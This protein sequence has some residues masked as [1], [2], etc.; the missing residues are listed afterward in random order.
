[1]LVIENHGPIILSSNF[2]GSEMDR[3]GRLYLSI[4]AGA[5]RLLL[6]SGWEPM[7]DEMRTGKE[8]IFSRGP[9]A[10][11]PGRGEDSLELLFEDGTD[12]PYAVHF[13]VAQAD[14]LPLDE[15]AGRELV[16]AAWTAPRRGKPH[17]GLERPLWYRRVEAVP[18]LKAREGG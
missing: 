18:C 9:W 4:N 14:R 16:F 7:L 8:V 2:W 5:V 6:P 10:K 11:G 12:S 13:G 15:D 1:M 17:K 3:A